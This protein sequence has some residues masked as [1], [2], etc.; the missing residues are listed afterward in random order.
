MVYEERVQENCIL[1]GTGI[2]QCQCCTGESWREAVRR[3]REMWEV[4]S[5]RVMARLIYSFNMR[6]FFPV[7]IVSSGNAFLQ[8]PGDFLPQLMEF[9]G[10]FSQNTHTSIIMFVSS[11]VN[12]HSLVQHIQPLHPFRCSTAL[13]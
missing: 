6:F 8:P 2:S 9:K 12:N 1:A 7:I 5:A 3:L 4:F 10:N 11:N 13:L